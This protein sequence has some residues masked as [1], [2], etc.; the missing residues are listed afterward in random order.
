M[1]I[2]CLGICWDMEY[3]YRYDIED[4]YEWLDYVRD[5]GIMQVFK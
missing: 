4:I 2:I 5:L 1:F 3:E